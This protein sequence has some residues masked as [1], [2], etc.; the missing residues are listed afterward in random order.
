MVIKKSF[1]QKVNGFG[2][3]FNGWGLEDTF[4]GAK[5]IS[6]GNFIIPL[7]ST[8]VYHINHPPRSGSEENKQKEYDENLS[9]YKELINFGD[10]SYQ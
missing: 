5:V 1:L 2:N 6:S 7:L 9:K 3:E 8:G 4:F 10:K